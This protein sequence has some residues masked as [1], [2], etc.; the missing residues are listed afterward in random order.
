MTPATME[1]PGCLL[2]GNRVI[3]PPILAT[4]VLSK[5]ARSES[6]GTIFVMGDAETHWSCGMATVP[7]TV[8]DVIVERLSLL[9]H[10]TA[11]LVGRSENVYHIW[12]MINDWT[13]SGRKSVY[14]AQRELVAKLEGLDLDFYVVAADHGERPD[15]LVSDIPIVFERTA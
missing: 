4:E 14:A 10:V 3:P 12:V 5:D 2:T 1:C 7:Q 6:S 8:V 13:A 11:L 9:S 15:A